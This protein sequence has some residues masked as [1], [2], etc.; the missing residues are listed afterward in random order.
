MIVCGQDLV[1]APSSES[2]LKKY[3]EVDKAGARVIISLALA[4]FLAIEDE[5]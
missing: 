3:N 1:C 2:V 4:L 5:R